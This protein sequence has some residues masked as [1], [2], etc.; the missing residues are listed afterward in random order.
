MKSEAREKVLPP[1]PSMELSQK[2]QPAVFPELLRSPLVSFPPLFLA[3][4]FSVRE[5]PL[6]GNLAKDSPE[7]DLRLRPYRE[8]QNLPNRKEEELSEEI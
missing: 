5:G 3:P 1:L 4:P 7:K 2:I 8:P 6:E